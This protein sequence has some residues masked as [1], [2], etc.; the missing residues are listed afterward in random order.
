MARK[1]N[2]FL[3]HPIVAKV[4]GSLI[5]IAILALWQG[6]REFLLRILTWFFDGI[7]TFWSHLDSTVAIPWWLVYVIVVMLLFSVFRAIRSFTRT[8][9]SVEEASVQ[10]TQK[11]SQDPRSYVADIFHD[12]L[13]KWELDAELYPHG[14]Q[15]FC[16]QCDMELLQLRGPY[17]GATEFYCEK[18]KKRTL[19]VHPIGGFIPSMRREIQRR[20]RTGEWESKCSAEME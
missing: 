16:P 13:W 20:I 17:P 7:L 12:V 4:I 8:R 15:A 19:V 6:L 18:C 3:R 1:I 5:L 10:T 2:L 11:R 14:F 9:S